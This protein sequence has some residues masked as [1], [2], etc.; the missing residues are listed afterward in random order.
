V[1]LIDEILEKNPRY[2]PSTRAKPICPDFDGLTVGEFQDALRAIE[3]SAE[4]H[5]KRIMS[6]GLRKPGV[7]L[8]QTGCQHGGCNGGGEWVLVLKDG[9]RW[10]VDE[11]RRWLS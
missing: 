10:R 8:V 5:D 2:Q 9:D 6:C 7:I 3:E 4:V 1:A 11:V